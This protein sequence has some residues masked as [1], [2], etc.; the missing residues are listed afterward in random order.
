MAKLYVVRDLTQ[1]NN[2]LVKYFKHIIY[3]ISVALFFFRCVM[4]DIIEGIKV[5][6]KHAN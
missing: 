2:E 6:Q 3:Y 1:L 5:D 4:Q